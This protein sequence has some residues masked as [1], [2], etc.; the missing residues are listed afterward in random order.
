AGK[1]GARLR[2]RL[3]RRPA[4]ATWTALRLDTVPAGQRT[5]KKTAAEGRRS[6][7]VF[8]RMRLSLARASLLRRPFSLALR[9]NPSGLPGSAACCREGKSSGPRGSSA[10]RSS[11]L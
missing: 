11:V 7:A 8:L 1:N 9:T 3:G 4:K 10:E 6:A 5:G 2:L